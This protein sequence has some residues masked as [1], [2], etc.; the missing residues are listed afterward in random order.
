MYCC[1]ELLYHDINMPYIL[2]VKVDNVTRASALA[3]VEDLLDSGRQ[4]L[5]TTPN[6]EFIVAAQTDV[7]FREIINGSAL[8]LPDGVGLIFAA[9]ILGVPLQERIA[10][11]DFVWDIARLAAKRG[12]SMYLLGAGEG[13]ARAAAEKLKAQNP[14]LKIVGAA[15]GPSQL[16]TT[17]LSFVGEIREAAP[18]I[19]L[20]AMGHGKQEK[21][22]V[23]HLH[24]LPSVKIAMGVGG[25]FDFIAGRVKRA[26]RLL[27]VLGLEWLW[28]LVRQPRRLPRIFRA[29]VVFPW[30]VFLEK[31]SRR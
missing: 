17:K 3:K 5:I 25:A 11:S 24:E 15:A 30:L 2:G 16:N 31:L 7:K 29:V 6:P 9:R 22:I 23:A 13:I 18:D 21:W 26:P 1:Q 27:R 4:H 14:N 20:V 10:G 28:R 12:Y 19:L 8:A